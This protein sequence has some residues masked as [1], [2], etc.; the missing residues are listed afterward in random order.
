MKFLGYATC[1]M[2]PK[3][4]VVEIYLLDINGINSYWCNEC[5]NSC[6]NFEFLP[7]YKVKNLSKK[8]LKNLVLK[9]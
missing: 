6:D 3:G 5:K 8:N 2:R 7:E 4:T 1:W 9:N